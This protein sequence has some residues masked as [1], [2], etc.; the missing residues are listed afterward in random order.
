MRTD[1]HR[2]VRA[3]LLAPLVV[4]VAFCLPLPGREFSKPVGNI[5]AHLV[6]YTIYA[7]PLAY[8]GELLFGVPAWIAFRHY[9]IRSYAA[10]GAGG[11]VLGLVFYLA[12][13]ASVGDFQRLTLMFNPLASPYLSIDIV[14]AS[15]SAI[16]F[17]AVVFSGVSSAP[18]K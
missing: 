16:L 9:G 14:A 2:A 6:V 7:V 18:P 8:V 3:F 17:R 11:A 12:M 15:A 10:F 1:T 4:P 5:L 13:E